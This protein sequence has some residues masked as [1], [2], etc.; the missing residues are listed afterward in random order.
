VIKQE[1]ITA[2]HYVQQQ[3]SRAVAV[4]LGLAYHV[5]LTSDWVIKAAI[6]MCSAFKSWQSKLNLPLIDKS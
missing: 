2:Q 4:E 6:F 5:L 1:Q 3:A